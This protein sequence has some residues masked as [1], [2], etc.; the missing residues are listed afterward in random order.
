M[1]RGDRD[2]KLRLIRILEHEKLGCLTI[3]D[4]CLEPAITANA[5]V[6]VY[7]SIVEPELGQA[8]NDKIGIALSRAAA[9]ALRNAIAKELCLGDEEQLLIL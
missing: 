2:I 1:Q 5:M 9:P 6:Y 4:D 7:Y 8:L 3:G